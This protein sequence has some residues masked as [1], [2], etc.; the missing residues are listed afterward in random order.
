MQAHLVEKVIQPQAFLFMSITT[1]CKALYPNSRKTVILLN[2]WYTNEPNGLSWTFVST[3]RA[4]HL[5]FSP[6]ASSN[7]KLNPNPV[8]GGNS[9]LAFRS[10]TRSWTATQWQ[11]RPSATIT[12]K[13]A[14]N[15]PD[16]SGGD[17]SEV[18]QNKATD[19]RKS[20]ALRA[21]LSFPPLEHW[22]GFVPKQCF[23]VSFPFCVFYSIA[24][25]CGKKLGK[26]EDHRKPVGLLEI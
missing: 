9:S 26:L 20:G 3:A 12:E 11:N 15:S 1:L 22:P 4:E 2:N 7:T 8:E 21:D 14:D 6:N 24:P 17:A 16:G 13:H 19:R 5:S 25:A 23:W 10:E 18:V